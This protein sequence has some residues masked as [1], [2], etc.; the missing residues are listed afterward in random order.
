MRE[1]GTVFLFKWLNKKN[2]QR[3]GHDNTGL[4]K[5][6]HLEKV[7]IES[8]LDDRRYALEGNR[9]FDR[10]KDDKQIERELNAVNF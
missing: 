3:I 10:N 6:W 5:G 1:Y 9:W 2:K 8:R 4:G 7:I